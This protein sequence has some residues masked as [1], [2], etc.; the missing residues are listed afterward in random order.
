MSQFPQCAHSLFT[1]S[2]LHEARV[3][4]LLV[5]PDHPLRGHWRM[6]GGHSTALFHALQCHPDQ[7][8]H[9]SKHTAR[10]H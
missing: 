3:S 4:I 8:G 6:A 10:D 1:H 9:L 2:E 7:H 5:P